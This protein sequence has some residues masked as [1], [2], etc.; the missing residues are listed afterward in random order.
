MP[1]GKDALPPTS[2]WLLNLKNEFQKR[3]G[4][5]IGM[6]P[7]LPGLADLNRVTLTGLPGVDFDHQGIAEIVQGGIARGGAGTQTREIGQRGYPDIAHDRTT[8]T[9]RLARGNQ[10][11]LVARSG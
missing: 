8:T 2:F 10:E 1:A 3:L 4:H 7:R 11:A 6:K 5:V 9:E